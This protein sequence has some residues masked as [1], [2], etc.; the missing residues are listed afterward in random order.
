MNVGESDLA[1]VAHQVLEVLPLYVG[2][3][4]LNNQSVPGARGRTIAI[5]TAT[6]ASAASASLGAGHL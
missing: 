6:A 5:P 1:G 2:A 4:V 3:Q